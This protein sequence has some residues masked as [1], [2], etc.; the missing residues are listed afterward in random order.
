MGG[1]ARA[2]G[3][4]KLEFGERFVEEMAAGT[5]G[6][7]KLGKEIAIEIVE[8]ENQVEAGLGRNGEASFPEEKRR[9]ATALLRGEVGFDEDEAG[10][11]GGNRGERRAVNREMPRGGEGGGAVEGRGRVIDGDD[12]PVVLGEIDSVLAGAAGEV[13]GAR[14]GMWARE[15]GE[16]FEEKGGGFRGRLGGGFAVAKVPTVE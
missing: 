10:E 13:E 9:R 15:Q 3:V 1:V 16:A 12:G 11:A 5:E 8:A 7:F 6:E 4:R 14:M 2:F